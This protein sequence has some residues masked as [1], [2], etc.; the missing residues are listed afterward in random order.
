MNKC[1]IHEP[2]EIKTKIFAVVTNGSHPPGDNVLQVRPNRGKQ[3]K[4]EGRKAVIVSADTRNNAGKKKGWGFEQCCG[5]GSGSFDHQAKNK[6]NLD[7]FRFV[8][9]LKLF[10][11][12]NLC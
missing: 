8:T 3:T 1:L 10:I 12:E 9:S 4:R 11:F 6:K 7:S 5:S 2:K